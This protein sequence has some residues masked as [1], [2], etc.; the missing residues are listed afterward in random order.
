M[1]IHPR[2]WW[3]VLAVLVAVRVAVPLAAL[4]DSGGGLP[5]L[6]H[7]RHDG[8]TGDASGYYSAARE[9][10]GSLRGLGA[11]GVTLLGL[12]LVASWW[13]IARAWRRGRLPA[14]WA[15]V[16][17]ALVAGLA[18]AS[19]ITRMS[20][21]G[22]AVFG[23]PLL[24]SIPLL[25]LRALHVLNTS[26]AFGVGLTLS[27]LATSATT[28]ATAFIGLRATTSR[29]VG[30]VAAGL[31]AFWPLL[32]GGIA[33]E[34]AWANGS[35]TTDV[36][37]AMYTEP[38]STALVTTSLALLLVDRLSPLRLAG[39]GVLL[40][41]ATMVKSSNG[42][43]TGVIAA[44]CLLHLGWRRVIPL[45]A[46]GLTF[47]P[48]VIAYWP[49]GY[50]KITGPT[51]ERPTL[52]PSLDAAA[53]N[54]LDSLVFSPRTLLVLVPLAALGVARARGAFTRALLVLPVLA[55]AALY[56]GYA[57]T[58]EHPRFLYVSLPAV[59][60]LWTAGTE[61]LVF[62]VGNGVRRRGAKS[63]LGQQKAKAA[64]R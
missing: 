5:G 36:G 24:W 62:A 42:I 32:V 31:W 44:I 20:P 1:R 10:I 43:V 6:P 56:T 53:R 52:A 49:R 4:G 2:R 59:L 14:Q 39:V 60:V 55:N 12:C 8:F 38:V 35:W 51:A 41:F 16:G 64:E 3:V 50:P 58:A 34:D 45:V 57:Y 30:L 25:P 47:A 48:A 7:Y 23:W 22:A 29:V 46:G 15:V 61:T 37:L 54:W 33:G 28:I 18:G 17:G 19:V 27:L 63:R 26:T 11:P 21:P 9:F 13:L 40:S